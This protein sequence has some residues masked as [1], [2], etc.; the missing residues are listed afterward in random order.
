[1]TECDADHG[2]DKSAERFS[3]TGQYDG[4]ICHQASGEKLGR[5]SAD[6]ACG[7]GGQR[8]EWTFLEFH[9]HPDPDSG[10][11]DGR[12][13]LSDQKEQI[14]ERSADQRSDL[15]DNG[16]YDQRCK[17]AECHSAQTLDKYMIKYLF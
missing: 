16:P 4:A 11:G 9:R 8:N 15:L 1:M 6:H 10:A 3:G 5:E 14:A 12:C 17:E 7:S 2:C 13:H